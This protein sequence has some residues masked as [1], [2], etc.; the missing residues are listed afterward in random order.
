MAR[1]EIVWAFLPNGIENGKLRFSAAASIRLPAEAGPRPNLGLFPEVLD[2]AAAVREMTFDVQFDKAAPVEAKRTSPDPDP[3]LWQAVFRPESPV[4]PFKFVDLSRRPIFAFPVKHVQSFIAQQYL[5]VAAESPEEPPA[6]ER[7]FRSEALAQV[8][9][10]PVASPRF[11]GAVQPRTTEA[12]LAQSLRAAVDRQKVKAVPVSEKPSPPQDFYLMRLYHQPRGKAVIDPKLKKPVVPR[13]PLAPPELDFHQAVSSLSSYPALMRLLGLAADFEV[14]LPAGVGKG[15]SLLA[16]VAPRGRAE[17]RSPWTKCAL[18]AAKGVFEAAARAS[19]PDVVDGFLD[20]SDESKFD[21]VQID[22]DGAALKTAELA[23]GAEDRA[24]GDLP[25][26]RSNG[27]SVVRTG[28]AVV[29]AEALRVSADLD[30]ALA[31]RREAIFYAEDLVQ[32]YRVD[33]WDESSGSWRSLCKRVG[34]YNF[35]RAGRVETLEDEGFV[36]ES[37]TEAAD[38]SSDDM[39]T[40]EAVF[41]WDGWSLVAP[42]PGRTIDKDDRAAAVQ[43]QAATAFRL[44]TTFKPAPGSLPRLRFGGRYRIRA[45]AVDLA[46]NSVG[47]ESADA[48][49]AIPAPPKPPL[50]Y[51]RFDP[52]AP[53]VVVPREEPKRGESVDEMVIRS[54]NDAVA[55]DTVA[56]GETAERHVVP[57]KTSELGAETHGMFDAAGGGVRKDVYGLIARRDP[58]RLQEVEPAETLELPYFPDPWAKGVVVRGLPGFPADKPLRI[59]L[60]GEW[61]DARPFRIRAV[62]GDRPAE[63]NAASRVLTVS[64]KKSDL[65]TLRLS[66]WFPEPMLA[67]VGLFRWLERPEIVI[68]KAILQAPQATGPLLVVPQGVRTIEAE[69]AERAGMAEAGAG[70]DVGV[71]TGGIAAKVQAEKIQAQPVRPVQAAP[72]RE[73]GPVFQL[74]RINLGLI[75]NLAVNASHWMMTP[76]RTV[77]LTHA[78][79]QPIGRPAAKSFGVVR[80]LGETHA[81]FD[82]E[83]AVHGSSSQKFDL[84]A[85]WKEPIDNVAEKTWRTLD[86]AAHVLEQPLGRG[87]ASFRMNDP[88]AHRQEF[89]DTKYRRVDYVVTA[90]TRFREQMPEGIAGDPERLVRRSATITVDVPNTAPP[91]APRV[92]YVVPT[93]GWERKREKNL[94]TSRRKGGGLRVYLERPWF[95]SG[96]GELL[97]VIL[98]PTPG[99]PTERA[100]EAAV[101]AARV[102]PLPAAAAKVQAVL[103]KAQVDVQAKTA[104]ARVAAAPPPVPEALRPYVTMWGLDPLWR[105][106]T[107][108]SPEYPLPGDF[109]LAREVLGGLSIP[110]LPDARSFTAVG[111]R[112]EYDGERGLWCCDI[113]IEPR[114]AYFPFVRLALARFQP[115]SVAGAHLSKVVTADFIQLVPDRTVSLDFGK[116]GQ[117]D[118]GITVSGPSYIQAAAGSGPGE[119]EVA[120]ETHDPGLPEEIDWSAVKG[121]SVTLKAQRASSGEPGLFIWTGKLAVPKGFQPK[122]ARVAVREYE[123]FLADQTG[124][125]ALK[126]AAAAAQ[127]PQAKARRL[128]FA[129]TFAFPNA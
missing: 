9:L 119:V 49:K 31:G 24:V 71:R 127:A 79:Q 38:E 56:T 52:V 39:F 99:V 68:P 97:G 76:F 59:E 70:A 11:A 103:P 21:I 55:K 100:A 74:P 8:R 15:G 50:A 114:A 111:H 23:D 115:V 58:G 12:V 42:R 28:N 85:T 77:V 113:E 4:A 95:S 19:K 37:V 67:N 22:V 30:R 89:G 72:A 2:W 6:M 13:L 82:A 117:G 63:W 69:R 14:D 53:P 33:V 73:L 125:A 102:A 75:K 26:L 25:A 105:A 62:E 81:R 51:A 27:L 124:L 43:S 83:L 128:V 41:G 87:Q 98:A 106:G 86:G 92:L 129:E 10:R 107:I 64:L 91:A 5:N 88:A 54:F 18:N 34:T 20:L 112:P 66:C 90:T 126:V 29:I 109:R 35:L 61:P 120:L 93:F 57:P 110:D 36:S 46:G 80:G 65:V 84:D 108:A 116:S 94:L 1:P 122:N 7:V 17:D 32:G 3:D 96:D 16:R 45:R 60:D 104:A 118:L 44:E 123:T 40:H 121:G 47:P 101:A 78:V 48:A